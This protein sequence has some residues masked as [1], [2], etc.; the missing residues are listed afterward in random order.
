M[1]DINPR[2]TYLLTNC[3]LIRMAAIARSWARFVSRLSWE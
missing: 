3:R 2:F 1:R